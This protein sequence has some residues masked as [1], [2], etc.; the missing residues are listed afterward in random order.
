[1]TKRV[2]FIKIGYWLGIGAD[3]LWAAILASPYLY[4]L[5]TGTPDFNPDFQTRQIMLIA[6]MLMSGWTVLLIWGV[7]N[8]IERR[9]IILLTAIVVLSLFLV[10]VNGYLSGNKVLLWI[11][12]K[13]PLL[14][15]SM[16]ISYLLS[17]KSVENID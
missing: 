10:A 3:A 7:R 5:V 12:I 9:F 8:P 4:G 1:M 13:S 17:G 15:I 14:F 11:L 2:F 16:T 6:A